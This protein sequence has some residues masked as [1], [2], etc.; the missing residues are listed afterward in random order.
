MKV[1]CDLHALLPGT[2]TMIPYHELHT[3]TTHGSP[4]LPAPCT[5]WICSKSNIG[6]TD[7]RVRTGGLLPTV[8]VTAVTAV[9]THGVSPGWAT[10]T[11]TG[12]MAKFQERLT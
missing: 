3:L 8:T 11:S 1:A 7:R 5:C 2:G 12:I 10:G 9:G 4:K 6:V